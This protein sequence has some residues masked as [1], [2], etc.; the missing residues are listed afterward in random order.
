MISSPCLSMI[1]SENRFPLFRIMREAAE[2]RQESSVANFWKIVWSITLAAIAGGLLL[3]RLVP[4]SGLYIAIASVAFSVAVWLVPP[5]LM[6]IPPKKPRHSLAAVG[7]FI[8]LLVTGCC[9]SLAALSLS[10]VT[11]AG[12]EHRALA[13]FSLLATILFW[14]LAFAVLN[15]AHRLTRKERK[16]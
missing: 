16:R 11:F 7:F 8:G 6:L 4:S 10:L 2:R 5:V 9:V 14:P 3:Q 13:W 15:L 12:G 1:F